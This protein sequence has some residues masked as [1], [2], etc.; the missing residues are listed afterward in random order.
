MEKDNMRKV[1]ILAFVFLGFNVNATPITMKAKIY[2]PKEIYLVGEPIWVDY[3]IHN[4]SPDTVW[5]D[6]MMTG[7]GGNVNFRIFNEETEEELYV[8]GWHISLRRFSDR[9]YKDVVFW[10]RNCMCLS[11]GDT[12]HGFYDITIN[13]NLFSHGRYHLKNMIYKSLLMFGEGA[14]DYLPFWKGEL[15]SPINFGINVKEPEGEEKKAQRLFFE[16]RGTQGGDRKK[17]ELYS[18]VIELYPSSV[19]SSKAQ[20]LIIY[21]ARKLVDSQKASQQEIKKKIEKLINLYPDSPYSL[22]YKNSKIQIQR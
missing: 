11:P 14:P 17:I 6:K 21:Y 15:E 16:V 19:Y 20:D 22:S 7:E 13:Y 12:L 3:F 18:K 4:I 10:K 9:Y 2:N 5:I 1:F 8:G